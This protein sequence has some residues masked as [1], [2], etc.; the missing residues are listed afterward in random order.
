MYSS[1]PLFIH[2]IFCTEN[3]KGSDYL[4]YSDVGRV[5]MN[6]RHMVRR[7]GLS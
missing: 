6:F 2:T 1:L 7:Y 5:Q 4:C 3:I